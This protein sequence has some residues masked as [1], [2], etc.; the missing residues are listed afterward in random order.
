MMNASTAPRTHEWYRRR[1]ANTAINH[2][3]VD[4]TALEAEALTLLV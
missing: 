4:F 1:L 2:S 3:K